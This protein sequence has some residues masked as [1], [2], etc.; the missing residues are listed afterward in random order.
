[1]KLI[2]VRHAQS[3]FNAEDRFAGQMDPELSELGR[4]TAREA[5]DE[6]RRY[7]INR[8]WSSSSRRALETARAIVLAATQSPA[9]ATATAP[10]IT[11]SDDLRERCYGQ[12]PPQKRNHWQV[13]IC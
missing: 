7:A 11:A 3:V 5:G 9:T 8:V 2:L 10:Q 6:L 4:D 1:M 12:Y 13:Q